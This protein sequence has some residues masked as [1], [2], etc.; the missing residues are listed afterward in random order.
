MKPLRAKM[1][2][3]SSCIPSIDAMSPS[4]PAFNSTVSH[5]YSARQNKPRNSKLI[6]VLCILGGRLI[7]TE[8]ARHPPEKF[9]SM[10]TR[11]TGSASVLIKSSPN[12]I[13]ENSADDS[14][15]FTS[16]IYNAAE[17]QASARRP[18]RMACSAIICNSCNR[19]IQTQIRHSR[20]LFIVVFNSS[21]I[22]ISVSTR[23]KLQ[24][25]VT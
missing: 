7:G 6:S 11:Q 12:I 20:R 9:V 15:S 17:S 4:A 14:A 5:F 19:M 18:V 10:V 24:C 2:L 1:S 23:S 16:H 22:Y 3:F 21:Q 13:S 8:R 25:N